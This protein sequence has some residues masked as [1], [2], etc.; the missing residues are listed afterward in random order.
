AAQAAGAGAFLRQEAD[1]RSAALA[2]ATGAAAAD[3]AAVLYNPAA[4]ARLAKPEVSATRVLLFEDTTFDALTG[5]VPTA[6]WGTFGGA[7]VRQASGGFEGRTGPNDAPNSFSVEQSAFLAGWGYSPELPGDAGGA[8]RLSLGVA[9]K[10]AREKIGSAAGSGTGLD[11][12]L[13][14]RPRPDLALGLAVGNLVAPKP[15]F[16][17]SGVPYDRSVEFSAA[18]DRRLAPDW[19]LTV[20][21]RV[22]RVQTEGTDPAGGVELRYGRLAALRFGLRGEGAST[23][24][25]VAFGNTRLDYAVLLHDLGL[26]HSMTLVQRFGQTR[27]ELEETI[28]RGISRLSRADGARLAKAYL[29]KADQEMRDGRTADARRDVEAALLLDPGNADIAARLKRVD[30]QWEESLRRQTL[31]R[32]STLAVR[33]EE[34]GNLLAARQYWNSVLDLA[35][36]DARAVAAVGRIDGELSSAERARADSLR[37]AE[38]ANEVALGLA[39]ASAYLTRGQLRL[40]RREAEKAALRHP[41]DAQVSDFLAQVDRR[42][43]EFVA[44]R[45]ADAAAAAAAREYGKAVAALEEARREAPD[46]AE[47]ARLQDDARAE[48]RRT[49]T[50]ETRKQAEQLY[51]RAVEQYLKGSYDA[52]GTLADEVL[53]LDPSSEAART[54]KEKVEAAQ[55][56]SR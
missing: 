55:R 21:A 8:R 53:K 42:L 28:R 4:L 37:R 45:K 38:A 46:D 16:V 30:A 1:A 35:P 6:R 36:G 20:L 29:A 27:E 52:A 15:A 13:L 12:G 18:Y 25:G 50:P 10:S 33:Q 26:S 56:Y 22:R 19:D 5:A 51:Y 47:L 41:G 7:F 24:V 2:G 34:Q 3:S 44:A 40:A 17:G 43:A 39:G 49:I 11:A 48:L 32:L 23:G 31:E 14:A 9:A 54:L